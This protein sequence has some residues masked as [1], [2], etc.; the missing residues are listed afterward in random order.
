M[1]NSGNVKKLWCNLVHFDDSDLIRIF[2]I[3]QQYL[4]NLI[5]QVERVFIPYI[6]IFTIRCIWK[7]YVVYY[8]GAYKIYACAYGK[9]MATSYII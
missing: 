2:V 6:C 8:F 1:G 3:W 9:N 4:K 5:E 7:E